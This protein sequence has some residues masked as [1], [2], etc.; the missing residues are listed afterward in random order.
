[1]LL[2]DSD[3]Q[4]FLCA[5]QNGTAGRLP[6]PYAIGSAPICI[7]TGASASISNCKDDFIDLRPVQ[8]LHLK[9][10]ATGLPIEGI[11]TLNWTIATDSGTNVT[12][13]IRNALY[14]PSCPMHLLS[15]QQLVRQTK[16][17][18]DGF[19]ALAHIGCLRFAGHYRTVLIEP[20]SN[21]PIL[22]TVGLSPQALASTS[23]VPTNISVLAFNAKIDNLTEIQRQLIRVHHRLGHLGFDSIQRLA[24]LGLLPQQLATCPKPLCSSCQLGKAHRVALPS[25][26][27]PLDSGHLLPGDCVSVDQ[28]E[29]NTPGLVPQ[30]RGLL[31][32]TTFQ[33]ATLFCNHA[34][35]FLHLACHSSTG[36]LEAIAAKRTFEREA[37]HAN[38]HIKQYRADNGIFNSSAWKTTCDAL[39]QQTLYCGVNAHHQ[40]GIAERQIRTIVDCS[41][42]MLLHAIHKWPD[43]IHVD[44]WP[45]AL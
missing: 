12:L 4:A 22:H 1:L 40:N 30:T 27:A 23:C 24:R 43:V 32:K 18:G 34:S 5:L 42:M 6:I 7:D 8:N 13:Q 36:A 9:G 37:A 29:S 10:I 17:S 44:L 3:K 15:P 28:L 19:N 41:R 38:V 26:G 11:G 39:Q 2:T 35:R 21:L 16:C 45:Y 31:T 33:A 20:S 25:P 14:V